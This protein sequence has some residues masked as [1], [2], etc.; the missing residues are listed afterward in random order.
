[1]EFTV[2]GIKYDFEVGKVTGAI[3][4]EI[5]NKCNVV[6]IENGEMKAVI[7]TGT[8]KTISV[9][10]RIKNLKINGKDQEITLKFIQDSDTEIC[11]ELYNAILKFDGERKKKLTA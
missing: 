2:D 9:L 1:M 10:R 8:L 7:L 11:V 4:E 3:Q 6:T 5:E